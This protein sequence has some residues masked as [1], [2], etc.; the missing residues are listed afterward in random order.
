MNSRT[1]VNVLM[2]SASITSPCRASSTSPEGERTRTWHGMKTSKRCSFGKK[3][4]WIRTVERSHRGLHET[5][6][7]RRGEDTT[8]ESQ[9]DEEDHNINTR[10][11]KEEIDPGI[12]P[13]IDR[14]NGPKAI[15][16]S[17]LMCPIP[18]YD[19]LMWYQFFL[20]QKTTQTCR[21]RAHGLYTRSWRKLTFDS[22]SVCSLGTIL[23]SCSTFFYS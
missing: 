17:S 11:D 9:G 8:S 1:D 23:Y 20:L 18:Q 3:A 6:S 14:L 22:R 15:G 21:S 12:I 16:I 13:F 19:R 2:E 10:E 5:L 7:S 4:G